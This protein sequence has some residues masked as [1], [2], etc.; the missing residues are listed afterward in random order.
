MIETRWE[1]QTCPVAGTDDRL[2]ALIA[3]GKLRNTHEKHTFSSQILTE[4]S[5]LEL[6]LQEYEYVL[7]HEINVTFITTDTF[8]CNYNG[9]CLLYLFYFNI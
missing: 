2:D 3:V 5:S 9:I 7:K 1:K 8:N 6:V 4:S